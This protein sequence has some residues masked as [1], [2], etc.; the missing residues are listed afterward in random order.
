MVGQSWVGRHSPAPGLD[1]HKEI[2]KNSI[3]RWFSTSLVLRPFDTAPPVV[4][5]T[6]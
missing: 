4:V 6:S 5:G 1:V 3:E 2:K